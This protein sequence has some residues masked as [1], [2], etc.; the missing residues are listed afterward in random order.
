[1]ENTNMPTRIIIFGAF[2]TGRKA[3]HMMKS[4]YEIVAFSDNC[5]DYYER[6]LF[7]IPIIPPQMIPTLQAELVV[8]ASINYYN[9]IAQQLIAMGID[10]LKLF[11]TKAGTQNYILL[12]VDGREPFKNYTYRKLETSPYSNKGEGLDESGTRSKR[13][14]LVIAYYFPPAGSSPIQRTLKFVKYMRE[15]GYEPIVLTTESDSFVNSYPMDQSL[16]SEIPEGI[17]I[18]RIKDD[19]SWSN[20]ISE[21][22][23][24]EIVEFLYSVSD[25]LE[26]MDM[27]MEIRKEQPLYILPDKLILWAN[28]CVRCI[29][30]YIDMNSIDLLYSTVPEWSPH[31][32]AFYLKQKYKIKWVADYRDPWVSNKDYVKLYYPWMTEAEV[33][34]DHRLE[35]KITQKMDKI[36]VAGGK[37]I[38]DFVKSYDID[39]IKIRE[40][41]NGYDEEDFRDLS[42]KRDKNKKFTLCYNGGVDYN[43]NPIPLLRIL[44]NLIESNELNPKRVQWIFNGPITNYYINEINKEDKYHIVVRNGMLQHKASLQIAINSDIMVMYGES[45]EKGILNYPGKFYEYLRIGRPILCFSSEHSFQADVLNETGLGVNLN[46]YDYDEINRFLREQIVIWKK[47]EKLEISIK[48]S[49]RKY[50]RKNLTQMLI[51][52]FNQLFIDKI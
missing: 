19:F 29:E 23:S 31:L 40:I 43:R 17:Q 41:T 11:W 16:L 35:N 10:N 22:K 44:N 8:I 30:Q 38:N 36:I 24:Q 2:D 47:E 52:E 7:D 33:V 42:I 32:I 20:V 27:F 46:L 50:E 21:K 12:D 34:L 25:S 28:E 39:P 26:W 5:S 6:Y 1:M 9:E 18:I 49:I 45:G 13:K 15:Y 14:V 4:Q 48:E 3:F 51:T 37:W